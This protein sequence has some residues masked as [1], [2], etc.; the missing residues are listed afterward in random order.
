[1]RNRVSVVWWTV[2]LRWYHTQ[3]PVEDIE[4]EMDMRGVCR[5]LVI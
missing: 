1:M 4:F 2:G 5:E 3:P